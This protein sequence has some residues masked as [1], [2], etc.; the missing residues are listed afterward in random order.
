MKKEIKKRVFNSAERIFGFFDEGARDY[1]ERESLF[2]PP[3]TTRVYLHPSMSERM[4]TLWRGGKLVLGEVLPMYN[5]RYFDIISAGILFVHG[6]DNAVADHTKATF[7]LRDDSIPIFTL[8][9]GYG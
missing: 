1:P 3:V 2:T 7:T 6:E 5:E 9:N 8:N 4:L